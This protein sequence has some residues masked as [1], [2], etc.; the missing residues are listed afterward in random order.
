M[1]FSSS[2]YSADTV[3]CTPPIACTSK[4]DALSHAKDRAAT[5]PRLVKFPPTTMPINVSLTISG[6]RPSMLA[7]VEER[8]LN[9][10]FGNCDIIDCVLLSLYSCC[11]PADV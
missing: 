11:C 8:T 3:P 5:P 4:V 7:S 1:E 10:P 9:A 2:Q 6:Q